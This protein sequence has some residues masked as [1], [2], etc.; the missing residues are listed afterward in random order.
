MED[1][2]SVQEYTKSVVDDHLE[3]RS[4]SGRSAKM[5]TV[6]LEG[7]VG[8]SNTVHTRGLQNT[9]EYI[10]VQQP[11]T[12]WDSTA[13]GQSLHDLRMTGRDGYRGRKV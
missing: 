4:V 12:S 11:Q 9:E 13:E 6:T 1:D 5:G 8:S 2:S 7:H 10:T 3:P